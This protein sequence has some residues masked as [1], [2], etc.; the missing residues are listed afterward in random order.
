MRARAAH[1][2]VA[3]AC[4]AA[5]AVPLAAGAQPRAKVPR[6]GVLSPGATDRDRCLTALR[7]G[8]SALGHV[9]GQ[10]HALEARWSDGEGA[11][12]P[13]LAA[14]LVHAQVDVIV[15]DSNQAAFAAKQA[16]ATIPIVMATSGYPV[17][18]GLIAGLAR[19][20]GNVTGVATF[21]GELFVKRLQLLKE[22]VPTATRLGILR[23]P[24]E[25]QSLHVKD[26]EAAAPR[27]GVH[28]LVV[29]V[30][31]PGD[32]APAFKVL[33][34]GGVQAVMTTQGP[35]FGTNRAEIARLALAHRLPSLSGEVAAADAGT[36]LFY[37]PDVF[38]GCHRA[39]TYV[40]RILK[41]AK[42]AD[43]PVE[44]P[45]KVELAVNLKTA[46][47]LRLTMPPALLARA[48]RII[49]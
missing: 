44:Q 20:G 34:K 29:T 7:Q 15:T 9:D 41:G 8:L 40:D 22:V 2:A 4:V 23:V 38:E 5:L 33:V 30:E 11:R 39:A 49:K 25:V 31:R 17:E 12:F 46:R 36:L 26:L 1:G 21:S 14:E 45:T 47:A 48:D 18:V 3:V 35:F 6:V 13:R 37:G 43:L 27:L 19:P 24:G 32:L 16:T 10:T 28:L 42:P